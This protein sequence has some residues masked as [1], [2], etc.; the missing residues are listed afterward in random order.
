MNHLPLK[1]PRRSLHGPIAV[2]NRE[3]EY[4]LCGQICPTN[5]SPCLREI[6]RRK[7][8]LRS[9]R[10]RP[11]VKIDNRDAIS[12]VAEAVKIMGYQVSVDKC[13]G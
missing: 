4:L 5:L 3:I 1:S 6:N 8:D 13:E 7:D 9:S 10:I 2:A 11:V 12:T